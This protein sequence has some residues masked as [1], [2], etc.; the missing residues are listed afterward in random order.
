MYYKRQFRQVLEGLAL[1]IT[2]IVG[3]M[4]SQF[5]QASFLRSEPDGDECGP[6]D[7]V[8]LEG[9]HDDP[10]CLSNKL[11]ADFMQRL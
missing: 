10:R 5:P 2:P 8:Q 9:L 3:V 11:S 4:F 7:P 1:Q 6:K